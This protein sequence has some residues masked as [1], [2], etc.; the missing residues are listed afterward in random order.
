MSSKIFK[1]F[2]LIFFALGS[3][4]ECKWICG[5]NAAVIKENQTI[6]G[7]CGQTNLRYSLGS[8]IVNANFASSKFKAYSLNEFYIARS[9]F[10]K[11]QF[12]FMIVKK[13]KLKDVNF[14][15]AQ[16][17]GTKFYNVDLSNVDFSNADLAGSQFI[18]CKLENV[19]FNGANLKGTL[20]QFSEFINSK[21]PE[22]SGY[23][24][25]GNYSK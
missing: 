3:V 9:T 6:E 19:I 10:E 1:P 25:S 20:F 5:D 12:N 13:G 24:L 23:F 16:V 14:S 8:N 11:A 15:S 4:A 2:C 21:L 17:K 22:D 7:P 18:N